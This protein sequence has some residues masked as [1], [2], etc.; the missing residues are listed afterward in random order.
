MSLQFVLR[1]FESKRRP[2]EKKYLL[3]LLLDRSVWILGMFESKRRPADKKAPPQFVVGE[4]DVG[5]SSAIPEHIR[6]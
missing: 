1:K 3:N 6:H 5:E 2:A 4:V